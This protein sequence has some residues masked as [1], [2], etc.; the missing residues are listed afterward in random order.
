MNKSITESTAHNPVLEHSERKRRYFGVLSHRRGLS[1]LS[2]RPCR[3]GGRA[4]WGLEEL[5][6]VTAR[7]GAGRRELKRLCRTTCHDPERGFRTIDALIRRHQVELREGPNLA[8]LRS[9]FASV[10]KSKLKVG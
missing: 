1:L 8:E 3:C 2:R 5:I 6:V 7:T 10:K 9:R 4:A